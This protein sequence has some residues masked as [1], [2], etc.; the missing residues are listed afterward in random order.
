[1]P[2]NRYF[3]QYM[4][5]RLAKDGGESV[6]HLKPPSVQAV[7]SMRFGGGGAAMGRGEGERNQRKAVRGQDRCHLRKFFA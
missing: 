3:D 4:S 2:S 7:V 1:M 5:S 6:G